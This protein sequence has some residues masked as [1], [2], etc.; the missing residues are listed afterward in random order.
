MDELEPPKTPFSTGVNK[1]ANV[2]AGMI[3]K[4]SL[5]TDN[6]K[7][8]RSTISLESIVSVSVVFIDDAETRNVRPVADPFVILIK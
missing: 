7:V 6:P 5:L 2:S 3:S 8:V 4:V 1:L